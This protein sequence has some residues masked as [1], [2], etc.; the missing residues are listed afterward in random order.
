MPHPF[1]RMLNRCLALS[2]ACLI[3]AAPSFA[4]AA[5]N[6]NTANNA[7][8]TERR[9]ADSDRY[10]ASDELEGRGP[11]TKGIDLAAQY[12]ADQFA[13]AGLKTQLYDGTPF[14][15]FNMVTGTELGKPNRAALVGPAV[16]GHAKKIELKL[17]QDFTPMAIGGSGKLDLPLVFAG[18]GITGRDEAYDDYAG[19]DVEGKAVVVL[20]HEPQQNNPHSK[21][22]GVKDSPLAAFTRKVSNASEHG[23]AAVIFCTDELEIRKRVDQRMHFWNAPIDELSEVHATFKKIDDPTLA[24]IEKHRQQVDKLVEEI[25]AQSKKL[26]ADFDPV[27]KFTTAGGGDETPRIPVLHC[28]RGVIDEILEAAIKTNLA[29]LEHA[30]DNGPADKQPAGKPS[31]DTGPTPH[32]RALEGWRLQ[33]EVTVNRREAAVKNVV[34]VLEGEGPKADETIV[35]GAHYDHLG[36]GGQGSFLPG[37]HEIHNGADDNGSGTSALIEIARRLAMREKKLPRRVVFIAFTGEERGL[38]GSAR[39]C[40]EPLVPLEKTVAM[41]NMDMVG[42]LVDD[43]LIIQGVDTA[44][45]FEPIIDELNKQYGFNLS[46]KPGGFGPSDHASFYAKKIPVMHFFTGLHKDYHRPSDDFDKINVAGMRRVAELVADTAVALAEA[47]D[48]P[49]LVES[50]SSTPSEGGDGDRP[51]VGTIPDFAQEQ[52]GYGISGASKDSP[53]DKAGLKGGDV[54]VHF[55]AS[56]I[57]SLEDFDSALRKYK[58]GDKV[59]VIVRRGKEEVKLEV[60]LAP[61]R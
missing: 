34:A 9:L 20:R 11:G 3:V 27:L 10:L 53:A 8:N 16:D 28:R 5:A 58:A 60:I 48:R 29:D 6:R 33:G 35:I 22:N 4:A 2:L 57:G 36:Y 47:P 14:Q 12:I 24:Q 59:P 26:A 54:I 38:I 45:E 51:Y 56:K 37:K 1:Q 44:A 19:I 23:A 30:I 15:K 18:Y 39:Y 49:K 55:G 61:P 13:D 46:K 50:K 52:P 43:K 40:K 21:F 7:A 25:A 42:R 31:A 32:S 17:D 41:L